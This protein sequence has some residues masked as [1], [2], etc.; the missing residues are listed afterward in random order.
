MEYARPYLW[1]EVLRDHPGLKLI[2]AHL[3]FPWIDETL[4]L[5]GKQ[6]GAF[7]DIAGLIRRP[8]QA[9]N[10][11]VTAHQFSVTDKLLFGSDFPFLTASEA[12]E[13]LYRLNEITHGTMLPSVPREAL[14]GIIERNALAA[15]EIERPGDR[16]NP[17]KLDEDR[18]EAPEES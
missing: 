10:S 14:R 17:D 8:W 7:A 5:L 1:D 4:A 3:G 12:I 11:L 13:S 9:Y 16:E 2:I 15:L 6:P 18:L